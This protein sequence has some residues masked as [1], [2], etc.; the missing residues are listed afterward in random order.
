MKVIIRSYKDLVQFLERKEVTNEFAHEVTEKVLKVLT[1][2]QFETK[3]ELVEAVK[4]YIV[5]F[6]DVE[7]KEKPIFLRQKGEDFDIKDVFKC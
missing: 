1:I 4:E 6:C 7:G 5:K 3:A 2:F